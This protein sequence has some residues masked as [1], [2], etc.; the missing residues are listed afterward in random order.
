MPALVSQEY[1]DL[2]RRLHAD[3]PTYGVSG[4]RHARLIADHA[5]SIDASSLLDY[6]CGKGT[7]KAALATILPALDVR[8]YDP[9]VP[10]KDDA[11]Q[12][13]PGPLQANRRACTA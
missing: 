8:E 9:A 3:E 5:R 12:A 7:L 13:D 4:D 11:D 2:N 1:L 10:G 6:G